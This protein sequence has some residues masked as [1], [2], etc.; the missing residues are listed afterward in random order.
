LRQ[1]YEF[2]SF[3]ELSIKGYKWTDSG[4]PTAI[5]V[6]SHGM[7][8]TIERYDAF[9]GFLVENGIFVYGHSH[10]GHGQTAESMEHLG[11]LGENGWFKMKEDLRRVVEMARTEYSEIPIFLLGHSM[12]SFL[13]RDFLLD[14]SYLISGVILSGTGYFSKFELNLGKFLAQSEVNRKGIYYK[15][16]RMTK[17]SFGTYNKKIK[18]S[19]T[20]FDW[21]SRDA[22]VVKEYI[23]DPYCG[24]THPASFYLEFM[25]NL[26]RILYTDLFKNLKDNLR[27]YIIS[28]D[29]DPVGQYGKGVRKTARYY[30]DNGF[31]VSMK[32]YE[33][34]RHE[35]LNE[36]NRKEVFEDILNWIQSG[37]E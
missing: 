27:M 8:E 5:L 2:D 7:A 35:M 19:Q 24:Q 23:E 32:L 31:D 36:L 1:S 4:E 11:Y 22:E 33:G 15:S 18:G 34:G 9:A 16:D 26:Y 30:R 37:R 21:L 3:G 13:A 10:R 17:I 12:G 6:I 28:G 29:S 14:Y 25:T 20:D